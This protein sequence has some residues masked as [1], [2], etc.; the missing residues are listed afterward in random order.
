V[1]DERRLAQR[2]TDIV[3]DGYRQIA[4]TYHAGRAARE[5]VNVE[6]LDQLR[7]WM[8]Q[9]GRVVDLGCGA[10][11]PVSRYFAQ[12]GY[13]VVGYDISP[14]MLDIARREVPAASFTEGSIEELDLDSGSVDIVV[15]FFAIIHV[16]RA[17]HAALFGRIFTWLRP[18]GVALLSLGAR[19]NPYG[20]EDHWH[21]APMAWSHFDAGT[22]LEL[23]SDAGFV[24]DWQELEDL[25]GER[26]L[27][28]LARRPE[29]AG[30]V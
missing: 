3:R 6:W 15:S 9:A 20:Y 28:V 7:P 4:A 23:L 27:Y 16:P 24:I 21:G 19:D 26:H 18:G 1:S 12:R 30:S 22:N 29:E 2:Q 5:E 14:Q 13:D 11:V 8:P 25:A 17:E 10:G